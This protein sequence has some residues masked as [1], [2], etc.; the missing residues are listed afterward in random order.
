MDAPSTVTPRRRVAQTVVL[1]A[2]T[3]LS[4]LVWTGWDLATDCD[5]A[6]GMSTGPW[7]AWQ[8]AGTVVSVVALG[9]VATLRLPTGLVLG[10]VPLAYTVAWM[11]LS[12]TVDGGDAFFALEA[13]LLLG[14]G[15]LAGV[16]V[17]G[18]T[19]GVEVALC[20]WRLRPSR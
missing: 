20:R 11:G 15:Y 1:A 4:L 9:V 10:V 2:L 7:A 12:L 5:P 14:A 8:I 18:V 19:R 17:V 3:A 13:G 16:V 6:T